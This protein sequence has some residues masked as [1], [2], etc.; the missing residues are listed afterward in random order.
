[1]LQ[2]GKG[3]DLSLRAVARRVGVSPAAPYAHFK[4]KGALLAA[5]A[6]EGFRTLTKALRRAFRRPGAD[7]LDRLHGMAAEYVRFALDHPA[8]F[9]LLFGTERPEI[10]DHPGMHEAA[11]AA[12]GLWLTAIIDAQHAG[13]LPRA[14]PAEM[15]MYTFTVLHGLAVLWPAGQLAVPPPPRGSA[16][17][18]AEMARDHFDRAVAGLAAG[19]ARP[20]KRDRRALQ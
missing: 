11:H 19:A 1:M 17:Q 9:R 4:D 8:Y 10:E 6:E 14:D 18:V 3:E 13:R 16:R 20:R 15:M 12:A 7:P 5:V 2:A